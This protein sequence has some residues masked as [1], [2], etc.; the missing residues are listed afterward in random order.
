M[1][2]KLYIFIKWK[3]KDLD[4][5]QCQFLI[6][7]MSE[8]R[9]VGYLHTDTNRNTHISIYLSIYL[10]IYTHTQLFNGGDGEAWCAAVHGFTKSRTQLSN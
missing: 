6:K 1:S 9:I 5:I 8:I 2:R 10:S 4:K 7:L 3:R